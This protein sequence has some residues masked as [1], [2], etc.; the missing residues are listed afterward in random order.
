M[1]TRSIDA[2]VEAERQVIM[3]ELRHRS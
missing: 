3:T 2:G 1:P